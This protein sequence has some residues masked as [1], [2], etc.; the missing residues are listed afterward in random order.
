MATYTY[1]KYFSSV[2]LSNASINSQHPGITNIFGPGFSNPSWRTLVSNVMSHMINQ[3]TDGIWHLNT[4]QGGIWKTY[5]SHDVPVAIY[6]GTITFKVTFKDSNDWHFDYDFSFSFTNGVS[7][8]SFNEAYQNACSYIESIPT[9]GNPGSAFF[10]R[11]TMQ[12][13]YFYFAEKHLTVTQYGYEEIIQ[14]F[15]DPSNSSNTILKCG[16]SNP[17]TVIA[18]LSENSTYGQ[19][20]FNITL[21]VT[22][23]NITTTLSTR[24]VQNS[25]TTNRQTTISKSIGY[26]IT[27]TF[28]EHLKTTSFL[29]GLVT[30]VPVP[31][32]Y[33]LNHQDFLDFN[34]KDVYDNIISDCTRNGT[35][36]SGTTGLTTTL[37]TKIVD[38]NV[39]TS[40]SAAEHTIVW[41]AITYDFYVNTALT[42]NIKTY[43]TYAPTS[44]IKRVYPLAV[45]QTCNETVYLCLY[46]VDE[47]EDSY[48]A[49]RVNPVDYLDMT[50][51]TYQTNINTYNFI[52]CTGSGT[53]NYH[54][55]FWVIY[56]G[57]FTY[58][59]YCLPE[60]ETPGILELQFQTSGETLDENMFYFCVFNTVE[61]HNGM[62]RYDIGCSAFYHFTGQKIFQCGQISGTGSNRHRTSF[63][64]L[65]VKKNDT[66]FIQNSSL[67]SHSEIPCYPEGA[68]PYS[69]QAEGINQWSVT[70]HGT[71]YTQPIAYANK[72]STFDD[73]FDKMTMY[74][75]VAAGYY[76][77]YNNYADI[78]YDF[79]TD[80]WSGIFASYYNTSDNNLNKSIR[81]RYVTINGTDYSELNWPMR[82]YLYPYWTSATQTSFS[83]MSGLVMKFSS[84][85]GWQ[86]SYH[87]D[88]A[89]FG[90]V[91]ETMWNNALTSN[92]SISSGVYALL[93][94]NGFYKSI[95]GGAYPFTSI[96]SGVNT[97]WN[98]ERRGIGNYELNNDL[99]APNDYLFNI[100][101]RVYD[102]FSDVVQYFDGDIDSSNQRYIGYKDTAN[103]F[104][105]QV[106]PSTNPDANLLTVYDRYYRFAVNDILYTYQYP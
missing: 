71:T 70:R 24:K 10:A 88:I 58:G 95:T 89:I 86:T 18:N 69:I 43:K 64:W 57:T 7:N 13:V 52:R 84:N 63:Y 17:S 22:T 15:Y 25:T 104:T 30:A 83:Y 78:R 74:H 21:T 82:W 14:A 47:G 97:N 100:V 59:N 67:Q 103:H 72:L 26:N 92:Q 34:A 23:A 75:G 12:N 80:I 106:P 46:D 90:G 55:G 3:D 8:I 51:G 19:H 54:P 37:L 29:K 61:Y 41:S 68:S 62:D 48:N 101:S 56:N 35:C 98:G 1:N 31:T 4:E 38:E 79:Y 39:T 94:Y 102:Y 49:H 77:G 65:G 91:S 16:L 28:L 5:A 2:T 85:W 81:Y 53:S 6:S 87:P 27:P 99:Q 60:T 11:I 50:G 20:Y 45:S 32:G 40:G 9:I 66:E 93:L 96:K 105:I 42:Q 33:A 73:L 76:W 44:S 36:A